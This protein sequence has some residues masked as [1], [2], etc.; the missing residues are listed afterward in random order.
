MKLTKNILLLTMAV[1]TCSCSAKENNQFTYVGLQVYDPTYVALDK[2]WF[3]DEGLEFKLYDTT[4]G[5]GTAMQLLSSGKADGAVVNYFSLASA[6][7]NGTKGLKGV[8]DCQTSFEETPLL[9]WFV[10]KDSGISSVKDLKGKNICVN[11]VGNSF[12]YYLEKT[13]RDNGID[14]EKDCNVSVIA[15][16][17]Q[18]EAIKNKK[19][20][21]IGLMQ[22]YTY[23]ARNDNEL[24]KLMDGTDVWGNI[25]S[26]PIIANTKKVSKETLTK[27]TTVL[28][29]TE[30]WIM[31]NKS[32]ADEIIAKYTGLDASKFE[33]YTFT[34]HGKIVE[35]DAEILLNYMKTYH[36]VNDSVSVS[37]IATNEYNGLL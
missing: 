6:C 20:D 31:E 13:L 33:D 19:V 3:A 34:E 29:R 35:S 27:F 1:L 25:Q 24:V 36:G 8:I 11:L 17:Q 4:A 2:G 10:R 22:P 21:L 12:Y 37:D 9:E 18:Y 16:G 5:T 32:E 15:F 30:D 28:A 26:C 14:I 7:S 23:E